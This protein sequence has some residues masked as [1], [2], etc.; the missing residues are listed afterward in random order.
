M[1]LHQLTPEKDLQW[2]LGMQDTAPVYRFGAGSYPRSLKVDPYPAY[3]HSTDVVEPLL[4][5]CEN[6]FPLTNAVTGLW[7][8]GHDV[9]D[10]ING[11]TYEDSVYEREDGS[12]WREEILC[13][14]GCNKKE[15]RYGQALSIALAA[16]R[17]PI[18][19]SMT[20]YLVPHEYGHAVFD[21]I[22]RKMGYFDSATD[23]L[24]A[25][26]MKLR[27]ITDYTKMYCGG[28]WHRAPCE[29]IAN[30]FRI[31]FTKQEM[32]Y[33]PHS[34]ALPNWYEAEGKWWKE[35]AELCGVKIK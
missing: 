30:D 21:Y 20:R 1:K 25:S 12:E 17:I 5:Q 28:Q 29:I 3:S 8:L 32:E 13:S 33:Y 16:K 4:A 7:L 6:A 15:K 2:P 26:Y 11:I 35:A 14:C 31:L 24:A 18:M 19:P 23:K 34:C 9:V 10:H 27:G 22:A